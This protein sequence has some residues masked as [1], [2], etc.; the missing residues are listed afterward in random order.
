M[1]PMRLRVLNAFNRFRFED[2]VWPVLLGVNIPNHQHTVIGHRK[3]S[4]GIGKTRCPGYAAQATGVT[5][6]TK[7]KDL[8]DAEMEK[9]A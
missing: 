9:A 4:Y 1:L 6:S 3:P 2:N 7:V 8:T 5:E